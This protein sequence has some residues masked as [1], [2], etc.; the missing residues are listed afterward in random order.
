MESQTNIGPA[1]RPGLTR[2]GMNLGNFPTIPGND[3][4]FLTMFHSVEKRG[5]TP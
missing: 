3:H 5:E 2:F 1:M 4:R